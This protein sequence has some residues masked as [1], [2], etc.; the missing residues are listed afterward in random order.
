MTKND[1]MICGLCGRDDFR[2]VASNNL[3]RFKCFGYDKK[4]L[5]CVDCGLVQLLPQWTNNE[6]N[7]LYSEYSAKIDFEGQK[8]TE[9]ER[10]YLEEFIDERDKV[11]EI[12][13]G[14]GNNLRRLK[15]LGYNVIGIDK[16][17]KVCDNILIFN[18][19]YQELDHSDKYDF[20]YA[21]HV[22]EHIPQPKLF[23]KK[24]IDSL[25]SKGRFV[26]EIPNV[27]DPLLTTYR[28][29]KF[30]SFYWYPYH[31]FFF[32]ERTLKELLFKFQDIRFT[33]K[34]RQRYGL[35]NH[36]RW[37]TKGKPGDNNEKIHVLDDVYMFLLT[38]MLRV[39]DT[40][41]VYGEKCE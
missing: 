34:L 4:V 26:L 10:L 17:P 2:V 1:K 28:V 32:N 27:D 20:I 29:K 7:D 36:L 37:I 38:R 6:L 30:N 9:N 15:E 12:G 3:I 31:L 24:I 11:L 18:K 21:I 23:I 33:I 35:R 25:K 14:L 39:S 16:D 41:I 8:R 40:I 19:D 5:R 22:M 13:C